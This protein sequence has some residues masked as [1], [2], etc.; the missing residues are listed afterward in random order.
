MNLKAFCVDALTSA[1][2]LG[3]GTPAD[4]LRHVTPDILATHLP[5][6]LWARLFTACLGA[7]RVDAQLIVD[8][9][10]VPNLCEHIPTS[11]VWACIAD[12]GARTLGKVPDISVAP[13]PLPNGTAVTA[14]PTSSVR[15]TAERVAVL[16]PPPD[17]R[18]PAP[19]P[20]PAPPPIAVGPSIPAP[21]AES[22]ADVISEIE[23]EDAN[24]PRIA[25]LRPRS[26]TAQRFRQSNTAVGRLGSGR[27]PQAAAVPAPV[28]AASGSSATSTATATSKLGGRPRREPTEVSDPEPETG[29]GSEWR[30][31]PSSRD[32]GVDDSQLVDWQATDGADAPGA[33]TTDED[34]SDLGRKR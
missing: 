26:P 22:L 11:I 18:P 29:D 15:I 1:L 17:E 8:T 31:T 4:V 3:I 21:A 27:R 14:A 6:P 30:N 16:A 19:A 13:A 34:F 33:Q 9:V 23:A 28:T 5:R 25:N 2:E 7:P 10:G 24:E 32:I 20:T 12:L